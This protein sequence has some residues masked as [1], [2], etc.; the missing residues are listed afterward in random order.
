MDAIPAQDARSYRDALGAFATGVAVAACAGPGGG[1]GVTINSFTSVSL[2]P[3]LVLWCLGSA[4]DRLDAFARA[5]GFGVSVLAADQ[6]AL[7]ERF[8]VDGRLATGD[9]AFDAAEHDALLAR[10][11]LAR[12]ACRIVNRWTAG[13]HVI[14]LGRVTA[15]DHAGGG[16]ALTYFR[17]GYGR[18]D[19]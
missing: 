2:E 9:P 11:A 3:P 8:T 4:S 16:P 10:G 7:A 15:F 14:F 19:A 13:D 1:A 5:A 6:E 12:L 17:G 18:I